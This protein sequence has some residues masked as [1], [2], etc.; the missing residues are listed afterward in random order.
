MHCISVQQ[1]VLS[2]E[3][4]THGTPCSNFVIFLCSNWRADTWWTSMEH[5]AWLGDAWVLLSL[6][7]W[8]STGSPGRD[9]SVTV[10]SLN[11]AT[12]WVNGCILCTNCLWNLTWTRGFIFDNL[13]LNL[14]FPWRTRWEWEDH[15]WS[16]IELLLELGSGLRDSHSANTELV[17]LAYTHGNLRSEHLTAWNF[18]CVDLALEFC[19]S[20]TGTFDMSWSFDWNLNNRKTCTL[21][22]DPVTEL[23]DNCNW[24][25]CLDD[26]WWLT[27]NEIEHWWDWFSGFLVWVPKCAIHTW[28]IEL[29]MFDN[30]MFPEFSDWST[31]DLDVK[32]TG[33]E[34][35]YFKIL[36]ETGIQGATFWWNLIQMCVPEQQ[37]LALTLNYFD[38]QPLDATWHVA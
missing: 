23:L 37:A 16:R 13:K 34:V 19:L 28:Q 29:W 12:K 38:Y 6:L 7:G 1:L 3:T 24:L 8:W 32:F 15:G 5:H 9:W 36:D 17:S 30:G 35:S 2:Y 4:H 33:V 21:I 11:A 10:D 26:F 25:W 14:P 27:P 18:G 20:L 31:S 22:S